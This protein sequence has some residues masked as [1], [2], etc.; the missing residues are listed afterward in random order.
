MSKENPSFPEGQPGDSFKAERVQLHGEPARAPVSRTREQRNADRLRARLRRSLPRWRLTPTH[1]AIV[2]TFRL[3][4]SR[5]ALA[6]VNLVTA[7]AAENGHA[8]ILEI[9]GSSVTCRLCTPALGG[10]GEMDFQ[11]ARR[12]S[13][14]G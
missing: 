11:L 8:P 1:D 12:I 10:V 2:R 6:F 4:G 13:L 7:L 14:L 9:G 5:S 3:T